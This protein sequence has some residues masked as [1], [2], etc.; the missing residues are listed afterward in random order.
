M[1]WMD[2]IEVSDGCLVSRG[3]QLYVCVFYTDTDVSG[4]AF[5]AT[6][7]ISYWCRSSWWQIW[8]I[9]PAER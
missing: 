5:R 3:Y 1:S 6:S 9:T 7:Q 4:R 2:M 8:K